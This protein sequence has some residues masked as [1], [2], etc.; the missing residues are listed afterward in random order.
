M[1]RNL[2]NYPFQLSNLC[3]IHVERSHPWAGSWISPHTETFSAL[4]GMFSILSFC[5]DYSL[6]YVKLVVACA[7]KLFSF[8]TSVSIFLCVSLTLSLSLSLSLSHAHAHAHTHTHTHTHTHRPS[9]SSFGLNSSPA[10]CQF[11]SSRVRG[12]WKG[13][14]RN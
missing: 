4:P 10:V 2:S 7:R 9:A 6:N 13:V 8:I 1:G 12:V 5:F 14:I 3:T 11:A